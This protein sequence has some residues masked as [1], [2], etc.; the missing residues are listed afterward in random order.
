MGK[1]RLSVLTAMIDQGVI[2]VF[3]HPDAEVCA[4]VIQACT[5]TFPNFKVVATTLRNAKTASPNDWSA[6]LWADGEFHQ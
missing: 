4:K 6:I 3:R 2:P 5:A 1:D